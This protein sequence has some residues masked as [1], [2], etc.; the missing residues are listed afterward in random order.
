MI[1]TCFC[2]FMVKSSYRSLSLTPLSPLSVRCA[3]SFSALLRRSAVRVRVSWRSFSVSV[4]WSIR[5]FD[6][7]ILLSN[8]LILMVEIVEEEKGGRVEGRKLNR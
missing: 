1:V 6:S 5:A 4:S 3:T 2:S 8:S 7:N